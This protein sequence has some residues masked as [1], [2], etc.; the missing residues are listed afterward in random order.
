MKIQCFV[1][2]CLQS[3][4]YVLY[5]DNV[6]VAWVIDPGRVEPIIKFLMEYRLSLRGILIT[7]YHFDHIYGIN[8]LLQTFGPISIYAFVKARE[9]FNSSKLNGSYYAEMP[10]TVSCD[11]LI[12]VKQDDCIELWEDIYAQVYETPGH[13]DD[14]ISFE[15]AGNLFT[16]DALIPG[17]KI[18]TKSKKADKKQAIESIKWI[19][20]NFPQ[21]TIIYPG[22]KNSC[23]LKDLDINE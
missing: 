22:H 8:K 10:F 12:P 9:G 3:N 18:H 5:C 20:G 4:T 1:N 13:N 17:V 14:C 16:G 2:D 11:N 6:S 19:M 21:E 15:V 23:K 7:H